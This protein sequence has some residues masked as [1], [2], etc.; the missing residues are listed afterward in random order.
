LLGYLELANRGVTRLEISV[1]VNNR[2]REYIVVQREC[3]VAQNKTTTFK[4][5]F[6]PCCYVRLRLTRGAP[7]SL[8]FAR[9]L[10]MTRDEFDERFGDAAAAESVATTPTGMLYDH[11]LPGKQPS[12]AQRQW[13]PDFYFHDYADAVSKAAS[14]ERVAAGSVLL[15]SDVARAQALVTLRVSK[16]RRGG[17]FA[18]NSGSFSAGGNVG[19]TLQSPPLRCFTLDELECGAAATVGYVDGLR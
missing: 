19:C 13:M 10:G 3:T 8:Y 12:Y 16:R 7:V 2:A 18:D 1:A 6:L 4:L 15:Q 17:D 9:P 5:G 11:V 14:G